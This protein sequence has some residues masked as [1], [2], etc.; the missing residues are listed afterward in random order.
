MTKENYIERRVKIDTD[1][2]S[3]KVL[4]DTEG[5]SILLA[6]PGAGKSSLLENLGLSLDVFPIRANVYRYSTKHNPDGTL[7]ID[8]LDEVV[9]LDKSAIDSV[10][11]KASEADCKRVILASRSGH[12]DEARTRFV[13]D[14]FRT[15]PTIVR[16]DP[17]SA[18]EQQQLFIQYKPDEDFDHFKRSLH[19]LDLADLLVNPQFLKIFAD[20][21]VESN[22][23]LV[24]KQQLF[25][26]AINWLAR[27]HS[28]DCLLYT[29]PS[30]RDLS[31]SRMPSSA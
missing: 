9:S 13:E 23:K 21:Y 18:L 29:S 20:A 27:E 22:R 3:Q 7:I 12:W 15:K 25:G 1:V 5:V 16:L 8:A 6:E 10:L 28:R 24:S 31:T 30:P 26:D 4:L 19:S 11:V 2:V 14:S 17:F